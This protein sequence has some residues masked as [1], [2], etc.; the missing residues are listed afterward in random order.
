MKDFKQMYPQ[1][2]KS[3]LADVRIKFLNNLLQNHNTIKQ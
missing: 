1:L 3:L 2:Y